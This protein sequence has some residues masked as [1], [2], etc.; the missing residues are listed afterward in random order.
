MIN[1]WN[2]PVNRLKRVPLCL[3][4]TFSDSNYIIIGGG[5]KI[6]VSTPYTCKH[7]AIDVVIDDFIDD[8]RHRVVKYGHGLFHGGSEIRTS[9]VISMGWLYSIKNNTH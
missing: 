6:D 7:S 5:P 1:K 4:F 3:F 2:N 8:V 9:L